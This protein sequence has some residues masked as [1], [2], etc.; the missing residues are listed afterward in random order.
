[1]G[2]VMGPASDGAR[3]PQRRRL[4][5][6]GALLPAVLAAGGCG[7]PAGP[8]FHSI[9]VT[10]AQFGQ[11]FALPD[12]D[13]R[14]RTLADFGGRVV[15]VFFGF[16][17]CPDV[18]P[19]TLVKLAEAV[20]LLGPDGARLQVVFITVDPAHDTPELLKLYVP[21]FHPD[22]VGLTGTPQQIAEVTK[23][24]RA[25]VAKVKGSTPDHYTIDHTTFTYLYDPQGRLRLMARHDIGVGE[26]VADI[27][28]L[29][30]G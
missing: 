18:C 28:A 24:F 1:M 29:L 19:M 7:E 2:T 8:R 12:F 16:T 10:G 25:Y 17:R 23:S 5:A 22:F 4:L 27:R 3:L 9:D 26:L 30:R 11:G 21:A 13:G 15:A 20:K 6:A 14:P